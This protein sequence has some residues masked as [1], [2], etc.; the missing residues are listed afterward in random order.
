MEYLMP[1]LIVQS[2]LLLALILT[3]AFCFFS[4]REERQRLERRWVYPAKK[5]RR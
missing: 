5:N 4:D 3:M 2:G 1:V